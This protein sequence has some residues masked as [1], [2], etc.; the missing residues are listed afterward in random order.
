MTLRSIFGKRIVALTV[1]CPHKGSVFPL[2]LVF[3]QHCGFMAHS[4]E[5]RVKIDFSGTA[6]FTVRIRRMGEGNV[7]SLFTSGGGSGQSSWRGGGQV[8]PASK[9]GGFGQ[10]SPAGGGG[11][12]SP[13]GRGGSGQVSWG[14]SVQPGGGS[15]RLGGG[16]VCL[17][18]SRRR[19]FLFTVH[20]RNYQRH[21]L[22]LLQNHVN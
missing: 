20:S 14:G 1:C 3:S 15:V 8:S 4:Y 11:Q 10:V 17:L 22:W 16:A 5:S 9:G 19:T 21:I 18:R 7:F 2:W 6:I 13:A 12:V